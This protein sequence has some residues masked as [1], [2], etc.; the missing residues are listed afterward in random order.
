MCNLTYKPLGHNG[1][2]SSQRSP[3]FRRNFDP[4]SPFVVGI[5]GSANEEG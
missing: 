1:I 2:E 3:L 5:G 4:L